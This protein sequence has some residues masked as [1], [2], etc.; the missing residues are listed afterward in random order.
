MR[1]TFHVF[2]SSSSRNS[3]PGR[4]NCQ[5]QFPPTFCQRIGHYAEGFVKFCTVVG[6]TQT[7]PESLGSFYS[8]YST[9]SIPS[10]ALFIYYFHARKLASSTIKSYLSA[11]SYVHKLIG[12]RDPTQAFLINKLLTALSRQGSC[13]IRLTILRPVLP[14]LVGSLGHTVSSAFQRTLYSAMFL[15]AF[16][17]FFRIGELAAK[18]ANSG[19]AVVQYNQLRFLTQKGNVQMIKITITK[20]KHNTTN[21][22]FDILI[23]RELSSP[24]CPVQAML[25][26]CKH[27][28]HQPGPL[29]CH[30]DMSPVTASQFN[31][32][33][34]R[35]L[36]FCGLDTSRYKGHSFRIGAACYAADKGFSD[37]QIRALG[38]WKSDAFKVYIRSDT[39][40]AN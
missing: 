39:L 37:A 1:T 26:F 36:M 9:I 38:R 2:R 21:R 24:F 27:R 31:I 32:E 17:G 18:S 15:L 3:R 6:H 33:L 20:F 11:I 34:H 25:N 12:L 10:V 22:L 40:H 30:T 19:S 28:G 29:F 5:L 4:T 7:L 14:E 35:C 23:E 8:F 16:Y 13:D